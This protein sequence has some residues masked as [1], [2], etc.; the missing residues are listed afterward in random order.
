M[1]EPVVSVIM[2][3]RDGAKYLIE[4]LDSIAN[5]NIEEMETIVVDD[6]S[7]DNSVQIAS[8]HPLQPAI[9]LQQTLGLGAALN[10]GLQ[11]A[12]GR[13]LSFLDQDDVWASG[14]LGAKLAVMRNYTNLDFVF[15]K[16]VNTDDKLNR[17]AAPLPARL[18]AAMLIKRTSALN[19]G[20]FRTD[21]THAT[22][23]DWNSR[24]AILGLQ[25][26]MMDDVV[27]LRRIHGE[28]MGIRDRARAQV[29]LLHVVRAHL[30]RKR[31]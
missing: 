22:I 19:V 9:I 7:A 1:V 23:I 18:L 6:G 3:V 21:I 13:Y 4:A 8:S 5:Q 15:G 25:F 11:A 27:L 20:L 2:C 16:T 28:N 30:N 31:Q 10:R 12:K 29:D 26:R 17:I 14:S 24:A